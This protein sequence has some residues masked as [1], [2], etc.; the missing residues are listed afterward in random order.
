V[1]LGN[2]FYDVR[3]AV[4]GVLI[5]RMSSTSGMPTGSTFTVAVSNQIVMPD[6][7]ATVY[8]LPSAGA[9]ASVTIAATDTG[10]RLYIAG[11]TVSSSPPCGPMVAFGLQAMYGSAA[12]TATI[13]M[14]CEFLVRD[15]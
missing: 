5:V 10:P 4:S 11:F 1:C 6:D 3:D 2:R 13:T 15:T 9:I 8:G 7:P 14:A 12:G